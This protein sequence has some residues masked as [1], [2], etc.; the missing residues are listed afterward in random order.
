MTFALIHQFVMLRMTQLTYCFDPGHIQK[1]R[2]S[3]NSAPTPAGFYV[4]HFDVLFDSMAR[5]PREPAQKGRTCH[6]ATSYYEDIKDQGALSEENNRT[7]VMD[8][9]YVDGSICALPFPPLST[10]TLLA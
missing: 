10:Y 7:A 1:D 5:M 2:V 8:S 9:H 3:R 4:V 6:I